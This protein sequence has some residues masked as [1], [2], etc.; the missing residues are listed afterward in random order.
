VATVREVRPGVT[1]DNLELSTGK[2]IPMIED[3]VLEIDVAGGR[4][5]VAAAFLD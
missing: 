5:V 3:A 4:V 2:L 1:N